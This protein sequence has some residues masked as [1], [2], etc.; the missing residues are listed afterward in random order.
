[1]VKV[2][3]HMYPVIPAKDEEERAALR[4]LGRHRERYFETLQGWHD[5][6]RAADE[7]GIWGVSSVEHHFHSEGYEVGS[8]P[9]IL[10]AYWAAITKNVRVGALGYVM[11]TR[12]PLRVAEETA[13][14]NH[15]SGG[16][17][18]VGFARGYQSRWTDVLGQHF[19]GKATMSDHSEQDLNNR[20][21]FE[22]NVD[23]VLKA[24]KDDSLSHK[25]ERWNIPNTEG[26]GFSAWPMIEATRKFGAPREISEDGRVAE[27]SVAPAPY[28]SPH[29]PVFVSSNSSIETVEW[30]AERG[31][32]PVYFAPIKRAAAHAESFQ[33][34]SEKAGHSLAFGQSQCVVRWPQ[35]GKTREEGL[36]ALSRYAGEQF[37]YF[38]APF[39]SALQGQDKSI[40]PYDL[41]GAAGVGPMLETGLFIAG[42]V[43]DVRDE[44]VSQ[45]KKV[46]AEYVV[47]IFHY[48]Q[49]PKESVIEDL[50]IFMKEVKPALDELTTYE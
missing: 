37:K 18:F 50:S 12:D 28:T 32:T 9:G 40:F 20:K 26:S 6:V 38:Y 27:I 17:S 45:W 47:L 10:N 49:Q 5:I 29:P 14:I 8:N 4:P 23:L 42:S 39:N 25:S 16:R 35:M 1:M 36:L 34:A 48:A 7:M 24:W 43:S 44:F 33:K 11:T 22:E 21:V 2:I 41:P 3:A 31:F 46:P 30:A 19:D 15:L 13:V